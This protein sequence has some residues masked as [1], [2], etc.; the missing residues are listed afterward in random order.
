M[1]G[2][3]LCGCTLEGSGAGRGRATGP[4]PTQHAPLIGLERRLRTRCRSPRAPR[5]APPRCCCRRC[6][7]LRV[8]C[9][10]QQAAVG[11]VRGAHAG[12]NARWRKAGGTRTKL[13]HVSSSSALPPC[14]PRQLNPSPMVGPAGTGPT[15][16]EKKN[17]DLRWQYWLARG[18]LDSAVVGAPRPAVS[19]LLC[20]ASGRA[21]SFPLWNR[22]RP[23]R[24]R[25]VARR[26]PD[27][28]SV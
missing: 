17:D 22:P 9:D 24:R 20:A 10:D 27:H 12:G 28:A 26:L 11:T 5:K 19:H 18:R 21:C 4:L 16:V 8:G 3:R 25:A 23:G 7:H 13:P 6:S 1:G 2:L 14:R 15:G